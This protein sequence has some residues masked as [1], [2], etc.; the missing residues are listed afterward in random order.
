MIPILDFLGPIIEKALSFIPDPK[1]KAEAQQKALEEL[2][3]HQE[4]LLKA[5]SSVDTAQIGVN[6]EEAKST[7]LFIAGWR[8]FLGWVGGIALTW[9]YV[10][11]PITTYFITLSGKTVT[12]PVFDFST[13]S[14]IL[15]AILGIGGLRTWEKVQG[16]NDKH[17]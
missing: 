13:M 1:M 3:R 17:D 12:L 11:Q 9:Q 14:T 2:N 4:E 6:T 5:L 10:L 8:P 16:V 15:M 7:N